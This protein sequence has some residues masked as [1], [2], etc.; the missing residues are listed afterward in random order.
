MTNP[1]GPASGSVRVF[2][3]GSRNSDPQ[4]CR[5]ADRQR[6]Y[7]GDRGNDLGFRVALVAVP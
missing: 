3:G 1:Q 2:R 5:S 7:P 4:Y 6:G